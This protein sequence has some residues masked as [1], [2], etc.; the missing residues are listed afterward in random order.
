MPNLTIPKSYNGVRATGGNPGLQYWRRVAVTNVL[1]TVYDGEGSIYGMTFRNPNTTAC[2][3]NFYN[4]S[5][6]TVATLGGIGA[7]AVTP[8]IIDRLQIPGALDA[9]NPGQ[10]IVSPGYFP[11]YYFPSGITIAAIT[12]D[13]DT[14]STAPSAALYAMLQVA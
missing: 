1:Q 9:S 10:L 2:F 7:V 11:I 8:L 12:T 4:G 14:G 13:S 3:V 6:S 5:T